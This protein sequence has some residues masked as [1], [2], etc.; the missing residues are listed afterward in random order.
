MNKRK[1][2]EEA[3][4]SNS[5]S[6]SMEIVWQTPA[7]PPEPQDYILR[8][9]NNQKFKNT[10]PFQT[11]IYQTQIIIK[12]ESWTKQNKTKIKSNTFQFN[13]INNLQGGATSDRTTSSSS[14]TLVNWS[15]YF[16][17]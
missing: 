3:G 5:N 14:L 7:N 12:I 10:P 1:R 9:G 6:N 16:N 8:N 17:V 11:K 13:F 4:N 2:E 15:N